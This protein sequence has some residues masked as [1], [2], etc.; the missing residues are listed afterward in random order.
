MPKHQLFQVGQNAIIRNNK[1]A[2][3]IL[4]HKGSGKW[5]LPGGRINK[6]EKWLDGFK[7]EI[8]EETG[9]DFTIDGVLDIDSFSD[10]E[11]FHYLVTF[12][13]HTGDKNVKLSNEHNDYA[14]I[15]NVD[16]LEKYNFWHKD[17]IK[18]IKKAFDYQ[19]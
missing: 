6:G 19:N 10:T 5:L 12:I 13:C 17:I 7:R 11:G 1:G 2:I 9:I 8:K 16:E 18:R 15:N 4:R 14:W 3:L